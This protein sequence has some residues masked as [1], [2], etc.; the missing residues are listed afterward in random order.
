[1]KHITL[2]LVIAGAIAGSKPAAAA[3]KVELQALTVC[4]D[5]DMKDSNLVL[6]EPSSILRGIGVDVHWHSVAG[7]P[8]DAMLVR[9]LKT[10]PATLPPQA[11]GCAHP[12]EGRSAE[13]YMDRVRAAVVPDKVASLTGYVIA[14]EIIHLLEGEGTRHAEEGI[15]RTRWTRADVQVMAWG[16]K[17][18]AQDIE[19]IREGL[20]ER[21]TR[22]IAAVG[23]VYEPRSGD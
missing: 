3:H 7:C 4:I 15:M 8:D 1:M 21:Q 20:R 23:S 2:A 16:W 18:T 5:R 10:A 6:S 14:H 12:L 9:V 22:T 17:L 13:V 19:L 11:L